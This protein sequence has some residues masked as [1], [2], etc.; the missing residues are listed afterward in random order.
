MAGRRKKSAKQELE[1]QILAE[2]RPRGL[3][4]KWWETTDK[5]SLAVATAAAGNWLKADGEMWI[6][7]MTNPDPR[8]D[9]MRALECKIRMISRLPNSARA[10]AMMLDLADRLLQYKANRKGRWGSKL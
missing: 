8:P 5:E 10:L 7:A 9:L 3:G 2:G 4:P 6:G 1:E